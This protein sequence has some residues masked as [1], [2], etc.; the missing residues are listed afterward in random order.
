VTIERV[1]PPH[2]VTCGCCSNGCICDHH[3]DIPR[4]DRAKICA[5]HVVLP[6]APLDST[7]RYDAAQG[8]YLH[9]PQGRKENRP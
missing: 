7:Y 1:Q 5:Y 8:R 6:Y 4:G 9:I 2:S 3:V